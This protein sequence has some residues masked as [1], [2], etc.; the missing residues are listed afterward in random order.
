MT[1]SMHDKAVDLPS[2][3]DGTHLTFLDSPIL[4][5]LFNN[6]TILYCRTLSLEING[7]QFE[8]GASDVELR[9]VTNHI[10][11]LSYP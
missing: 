6:L 8:P 11:S 4:S 2:C 3:Y 10:L 5:A 7:Y 1:L 9:L